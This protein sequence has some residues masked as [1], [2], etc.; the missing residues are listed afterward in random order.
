MIKTR[1]HYLHDYA[2]IVTTQNSQNAIAAHPPAYVLACEGMQ[3]QAIHISLYLALQRN[4]MGF[5]TIC[6]IMH[7]MHSTAVRCLARCVPTLFV[8]MCH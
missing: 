3:L 5:C 6:L 2:L 4:L 1:P 8:P 7:W